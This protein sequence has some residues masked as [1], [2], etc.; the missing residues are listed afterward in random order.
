MGHIVN[1]GKHE[2]RIRIGLGLF[3]L[4]IGGLTALPEW[5]SLVAFCLGAVALYTGIHHFCPLWKW[6]GINTCEQ[7]HQKHH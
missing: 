7:Q 6:L 2:S 5:A 3:L 4:A 1:M